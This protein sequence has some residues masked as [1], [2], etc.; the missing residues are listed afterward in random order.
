MRYLT[1]VAFRGGGQTDYTTRLRTIGP[2][3]HV[4]YAYIPDITQIRVQILR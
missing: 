1:Y 4:P 2:A 3:L